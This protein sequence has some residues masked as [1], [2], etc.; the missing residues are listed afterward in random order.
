ML[1]PPTEE[2]VEEMLVTDSPDHVMARITPKME[3]YS[4]KDRHQ[5]GWSA[6]AHIH[7]GSDCR[8]GPD[9]GDVAK[10]HTCS[11]ASWAPC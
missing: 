10:A 3:G 9:P 7:A 8:G 4:R 1:S 5:R 6:A 2:A 11:C